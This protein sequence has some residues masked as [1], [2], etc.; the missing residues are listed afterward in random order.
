MLSTV[1][2]IAWIVVFVW[3]FL[4]CN[5]QLERFDAS[6]FNQLKKAILE[7][8]YSSRGVIWLLGVIL[9][10]PY[11]FPLRAVVIWFITVLCLYY[12]TGV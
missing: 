11:V 1:G 7:K 12:L 9:Y 4:Y 5:V 10:S 6:T 3:F 2:F 8:M